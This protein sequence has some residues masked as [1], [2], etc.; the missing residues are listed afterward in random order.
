MLKVTQ[1]SAGLKMKM[2]SEFKFFCLD[3]VS[4][5]FWSKVCIYLPSGLSKS[6]AEDGKL[7]GRLGPLVLP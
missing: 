6:K 7:P 2:E 5:L 3:V 1:C 4:L